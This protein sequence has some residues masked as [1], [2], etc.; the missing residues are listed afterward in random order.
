ME[1]FRLKDS[2]VEKYKK[3]KPPFGFNG[4]GEIIYYRTYAREKSDGT[5]EQWYETIRRVV[6]GTYSIQ[7]RHTITLRARRFMQWSA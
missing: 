5:S 4:L 2:F 1:K 7:Q 6:E 3:I